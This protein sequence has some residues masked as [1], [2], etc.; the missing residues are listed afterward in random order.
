MPPLPS[1]T[2]LPHNKP[3]SLPLGTLPY[4]PVS[5]ALV[6]S[7]RAEGLCA[8]VPGG[9]PGPPAL[10]EH[11][12]PACLHWHPLKLS[13]TQHAGV[14]LPS[15]SPS[16]MTTF[17]RPPTLSGW[18]SHRR[19]CW[20]QP[21]DI[22]E[23]QRCK[24]N[25]T[26][27]NPICREWPRGY[28]VNFYLEYTVHPVLSALIPQSGSWGSS[29][30]RGRA[31]PP[32][33]SAVHHRADTHRQ[34]WTHNHAYVQFR[35]LCLPNLHVFG[36]WNRRR[37]S[38]NILTQHRKTLGQKRDMGPSW[39]K[40]CHCA[41]FS[42][43]SKYR[44]IQKDIAWCL[45]FPSFLSATFFACFAV[46][47]NTWTHKACFSWILIILDILVCDSCSGYTPVS[48]KIQK[49]TGFF[50]SPHLIGSM[51]PVMTE[52]KWRKRG[53]THNKLFMSI[54]SMSI[55]SFFSEQKPEWKLN[56]KNVYILKPG[57]KF[58]K[59]CS[60]SWRAKQMVV[61]KRNLNSSLCGI[62]V[63][64]CSYFICFS[65]YNDSWGVWCS[66]ESN[67]ITFTWDLE[68]FKLFLHLNIFS[69][70]FFNAW[71]H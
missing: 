66:G 56:I 40:V 24:L 13:P 50:F 4:P 17:N 29:Q 19:S 68:P 33:K 25:T 8:D 11:V 47:F 55:S 23:A 70:F 53:A 63:C 21:V 1:L 44:K 10:G 22:A 6:G 46:C 69:A 37:H 36:L 2:R 64:T 27:S 52:C 3:F 26:E 58:N 18:R 60:L 9:G 7:L 16:R 71:N 61:T 59:M 28:W 32:Y 31:P 62:A 30:D 57:R 35:A 5:P 43:T 12:V 45:F 54:S 38:G 42:H 39:W 34:T 48:A 14:R 65:N 67:L 15:P 41:T 20:F 51:A 49:G